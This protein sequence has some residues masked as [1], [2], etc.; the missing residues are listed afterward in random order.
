MRHLFSLS[1]PPLMANDLVTSAGKYL[2]QHGIDNPK[3]EAG[4]ILAHL[5]QCDYLQILGDAPP[6]NKKMA[7][8]FWRLIKKRG[9]GLPFAYITGR[10]EFFSLSFFVSRSVLIPRP[11]SEDLCQAVIDHFPKTLSSRWLILALALAVCWF[12]CCAISTMGVGS[13]STARGRPLPWRQKMQPPS[14]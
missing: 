12:H 3:R 14:G 7:R 13:A 6:I 9:R 2:Q 4:L 8:Q 5:L 11:V 1:R 10:Q